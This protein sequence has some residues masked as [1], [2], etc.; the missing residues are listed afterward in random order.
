MKKV[1]YSIVFV[2]MLLVIQAK[3]QELTLKRI[4]DDGLAQSSY[5]L[6]DNTSKE[7]VVIDPR[8]DIQIFIDTLSSLGA[9]VKYVT[10]THIHADYLSGA[11]ELAQFTDATLALSK[12]GPIEWQYRFDYQPLKKGDYLAFGSFTL[13][14]LHTPGHTPESISFLL[15]NN[16]DLRTPL[17]A[18]TGDFLFV[19]DAGRP[20]LLEKYEEGDK[21]SIS[22]AK[23]L[24]NSIEEFRKLPDDLEIWPGHGAGSFCGK[25]LST[26]PFSTLKAEKLTNKALQFSGNQVEFINYI[27]ADQVVPPA[28]FKLMKE[29]NRDGSNHKFTVNRYAEI[30]QSDLLNLI[31][32]GVTVID[33]R[34]RQTVA[35]GYFPQTIHIELNKSFSNWFTQIVD[36]HDQVIFIVDKA[37]ENE[38]AKKMMRIGFE[39]VL[40]V[41]Y[42]IAPLD[43]KKITYVK[44][45]KVFET[46]GN[47][48]VTAWD[49]RTATEYKE[50][51]ISGFQ[52]MPLTEI[53]VEAQM[54]DK[55]KPIAI[56]CQ[57][58]ARAAIGYSIFDKLGFTD[59]TIY[60]GGIN[61]WK[62][63]GNKL[64]SE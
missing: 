36:H 61:E 34:S 16:K 54:L 48:G 20:D 42:D 10:E 27:L 13:Q 2:W 1:R 25:T 35:Q 46:I 26:V 33:T 62:E 59:I 22:S 18:F 50:G 51:H 9:K 24:Y 43:K 8:K 58:G 21:S 19:G 7:A 17:K 23:Q 38:L 12:A 37:K 64:V 31:N 14:V 15:F 11:R 4:F 60:N 53:A 56:H 45:E 29:W 44:P 57:S 52:N 40:G 30:G 47:K 41:T 6:M 49:I 5:I 32:N 39:N 3:A 55:T 63:L 28:Y